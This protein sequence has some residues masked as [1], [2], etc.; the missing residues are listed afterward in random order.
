MQA[1]VSTSTE[2][3]QAEEES[4]AA[5]RDRSG[6]GAQPN[7]QMRGKEFKVGDR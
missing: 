2:A 6:G 7:P 5:M 1:H 4:E 3:P